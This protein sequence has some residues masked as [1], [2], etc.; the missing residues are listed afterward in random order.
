MLRIHLPCFKHDALCC[1]HNH[2]CNITL[3]DAFDDLRFLACQIAEAHQHVDK[4]TCLR[5]TVPIKVD[6]RDL[7]AS[8]DFDIISITCVTCLSSRD[9]LVV[10]MHSN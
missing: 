6:E 7:V 5:T 2:G 9:V 8:H 1:L 10:A 3:R 4:S